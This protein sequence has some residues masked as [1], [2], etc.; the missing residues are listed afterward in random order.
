M[1]EFLKKL[2]DEIENRK[3]SFFMLY[4]DGKCDYEEFVN[5]LHQKSE[6]E[7][8]QQIKAIMDKVDTNNMPQKKY[9]HINS[10]K[11]KRRNDIYEFKSKHLRVYAIKTDKDYY[12]LLG[13]YKKEQ[14]KDIEKVFKNYN[15][16]PNDIPE[17]QKEENYEQDRTI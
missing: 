16:V 1:A 2:Y 4:R 13:G 9:R 10:G 3:Y 5:S 11:G 7:E 17:L 15:D 12:L 14:D 6:V 8:L